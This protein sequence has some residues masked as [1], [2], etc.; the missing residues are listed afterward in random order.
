MQ[1]ESLSSADVARLTGIA[2]DRG[3]AVRDE[4]VGEIRSAKRLAGLML[5]AAHYVSEPTATQIPPVEITLSDGRV[6]RSDDDDVDRILTGDLG[7]DVTLWPRRP[8]EDIEHYRRREELDWNDIR[9]QYGLAEDDPFPDMSDV[10]PAL[11]EE[12]LEFVSPVG[13]YFDAFEL[14]LLTTGSIE[15]LRGGHSDSAVD[16]R[17][18]RPNVLVETI[19]DGEPGR[20]RFPEF[21]WIGHRVSIGELVVEVVAPVQ[22]CVMI[23]LPQGDLERDRSVLRTLIGETR[24]NFGVG[25]RIVEPAEIA[26][27]DEV[28]VF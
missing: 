27:G 22:R 11:L 9:D 17:R 16:V 21:A 18:F 25:L 12:L 23:S 2:G 13:T 20:E 8:A 5:C 15:T 26:I 10:P 24:Q 6:V 19:G 28:H 7:R 1:G 4:T 14:H 3:W